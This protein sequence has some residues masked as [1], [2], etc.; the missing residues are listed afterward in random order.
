MQVM[1]EGT[2]RR[3]RGYQPVQT[4]RKM[5]NTVMVDVPLNQIN[6]FA[7][8]TNSAVYVDTSRHC[9]HCQYLNINTMLTVFTGRFTPTSPTNRGISSR[10]AEF[11]NVC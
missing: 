2:P 7:G 1:E 6:S 9:Q 4:A 3:F 5:Y 10:K 8:P 11:Q